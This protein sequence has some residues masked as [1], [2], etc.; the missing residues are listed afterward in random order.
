MIDLSRVT[1]GQS[2]PDEFSQFT[3]LAFGS[4]FYMYISDTILVQ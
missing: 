2:K 3:R 1:F 4:C